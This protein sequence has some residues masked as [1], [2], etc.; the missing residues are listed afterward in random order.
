MILKKTVIF[1]MD[2]LMFDTEFLVEEGWD[3]AGQKLGVGK[4]G[5]MISKTLGVNAEKTKEIFFEEFGDKVDIDELTRHTREYVYDYYAKNG[6]PVKPY[7]QK[8]LEYLKENGYKMAVAS[9]S[10]RQS[11]M[12]HLENTK[13]VDYF[14]AI[15]C[16]DMIEHSKPA[17]DIYLKAAEELNVNPEECYALEDSP[18]GIRSAKSAGMKVI[19]VPDMIKPTEDIKS[20]LDAEF[21]DLGQVIQYLKNEF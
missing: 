15:I 11:V 21:E 7:L 17:P 14:D 18:N 8:L 6:V 2:G 4:L 5:Y 19:M 12:H 16:G 10:R 3:F 13:V 1:D 9:S 20:L